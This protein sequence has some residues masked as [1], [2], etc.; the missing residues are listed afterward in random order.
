[1]THLQQVC[2]AMLHSQEQLQRLYQFER[3]L[4]RTGDGRTLAMVHSA[5]QT[6]EHNLKVMG[7]ALQLHPAANDEPVPGEAA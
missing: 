5:Q 2:S 7:M 3:G 4:P 1:M 6:H